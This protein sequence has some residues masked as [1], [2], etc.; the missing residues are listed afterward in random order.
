[1]KAERTLK[2]PHLNDANIVWWTV[3]WMRDFDQ[4]KS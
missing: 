4:Y 3:K 2:S 1:M